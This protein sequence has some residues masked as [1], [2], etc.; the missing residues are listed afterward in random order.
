MAPPKG[1]QFWKRRTKH[2]KEKLFA[3]KELLLDA[4]YEYFEYMD[5]NKWVINEITKKINV[6]TPDDIT[7]KKKPKSQPYSIEGLC[8]FLGCSFSWWR[9]SKLRFKNNPTN[10]TESELLEAMEQI[11]LIVFV[12]QF[13]GASIGEFDPRIM[14]SKLGLI[15]KTENTNFNVNS[16]TEPLST[17]EIKSLKKK[18]EEDY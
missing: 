17:D 11:E 15:T 6:N 14:T 8:L 12:N 7:K 13:N 10:E 18:L 2:G 1:S 9:N 16:E 4:S 3:T 5:S